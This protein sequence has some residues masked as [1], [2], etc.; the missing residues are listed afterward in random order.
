MQ[1]KLLILLQFIAMEKTTFYKHKTAENNP[2]KPTACS[3]HSTIYK[4]G[5]EFLLAFDIRDPLSN[6]T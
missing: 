6:C 1:V 2:F 4:A 5:M 3:Q